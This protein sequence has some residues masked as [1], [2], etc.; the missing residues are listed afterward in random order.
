MRAMRAERSS[1]RPAM[2]WQ[3]LSAGASRRSMKPLMVG[4]P[5]TVLSFSSATRCW[6][7]R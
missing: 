3:V 1:W 6:T 4:M 5:E 7:S 2:V